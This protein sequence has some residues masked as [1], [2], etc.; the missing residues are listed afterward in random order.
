MAAKSSQKEERSHRYTN[1]CI[2]IQREPQPCTKQV[3]RKKEEEDMKENPTSQHV[4]P[5]P[6]IQATLHGVNVLFPQL[7]YE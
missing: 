2:C 3:R 4:L 7:R 6:G 1:I 5:L